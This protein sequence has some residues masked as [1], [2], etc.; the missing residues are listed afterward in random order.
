VNINVPTSYIFFH[1]KQFF[2]GFLIQN[3]TYF[4]LFGM[5]AKHYRNEKKSA[6]KLD[7]GESTHVHRLQPTYGQVSKLQRSVRAPRGSTTA[8][9]ANS[10]LSLRPHLQ[11]TS[12]TG[13]V[14]P[15]SA[16]T[17]APPLRRCRRDDLPPRH[18]R[19]GGVPGVR[20]GRGRGRLQ[21]PYSLLLAVR[22]HRRPLQRHQGG[23]RHYSGR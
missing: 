19:M 13:P 20:L 4:S 22:R 23:A 17:R 5:I 16:P 8:A 6:H 14:P 11:M 12:S 10:L 18:R 21:R 2:Y 15:L 3:W 9:S 1:S 7:L